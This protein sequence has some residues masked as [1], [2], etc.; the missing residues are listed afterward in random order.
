MKQAAV[1]EIIGANGDLV[2]VSGAGQGREGIELCSDPNGLLDEAPIKTIWQQSVFQE[3]ATYVDTSIEPKDYVLTFDLF[4]ENGEDWEGVDQRFYALFE[5]GKPSKIVYR[6]DQSDRYIEV[7]KLEATKTV[8]KHDPRFIQASKMTVTLR[9]PNPFWI[10]NTVEEEAEFT[11]SGTKN[12]HVQNDT[13]RPMFLQWAVTAPGQ[14]EIPDVNP[15]EPGTVKRWVKTPVLK[16]GQNLTVDTHPLHE[17]YVS[18]D[19]T[20][21]AG[22]FAGVDFI[23]FIPPHTP[24]ITLPVRFTGKSGTVGVRVVE[25]FQRPFGGR[26]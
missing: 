21:I 11:A 10:E 25:Q 20:N 22:L 4:D 24:E 17:T 2:T 19:R 3:G 8:T 5:V 9:A 7:I 23:G 13:D 14:W 16:A 26:W 1:I 12:L 6:T 18:Q 15:S